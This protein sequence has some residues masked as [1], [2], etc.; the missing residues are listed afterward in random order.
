MKDCSQFNR[1]R[2]DLNMTCNF[3]L[4][5]PKLGWTFHFNKIHLFFCCAFLSKLTSHFSRLERK[6]GRWNM[7]RPTLTSNFFPKVKRR[8]TTDRIP[9][10]GEYVGTSINWIDRANYCDF[11]FDMTAYTKN[12][13][14]LYLIPQICWRKN[15]HFMNAQ[16]DSFPHFSSEQIKMME[17]QI[18]TFMFPSICTDSVWFQLFLPVP[19]KTLLELFPNVF[20]NF[21]MN[22]W[23]YFI[24][25]NEEIKPEEPAVHVD[26]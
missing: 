14:Q 23:F 10:L 11:D 1:N 26:F 25:L 3:H 17:Y 2:D 4:E 8:G 6:T 18:K 9:N 22:F 13:F 16:S 7:S 15:W 5:S 12:L 21:S 19:L 20:I 24:F